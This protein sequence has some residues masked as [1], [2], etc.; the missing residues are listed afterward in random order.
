MRK[1]VSI[2]ALCLCAVSMLQAAP[3]WMR[4]NAISPQGDK[5]AFSYKGDIYVVDAKGGQAK[6]LTTN[7]AYEFAPVWSHDGQTIAFATDRN[8]NFDVYTVA[9]KGG[10]AKRI[11]FNS[12]SE[13]PLAFSAD[14]KSVYYSA[15][16]Q[17]DAENVQF[18]SGW[19]T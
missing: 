9:A 1:L 7:S 5:I 17:K 15:Y 3:L 12:A 14:D 13:T 19:M 2:L 10:V 6:Q 4:Y 11:T 18:P 8:G 16:I